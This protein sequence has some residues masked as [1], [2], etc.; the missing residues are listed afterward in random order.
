[1]SFECLL[2][3][4]EAPTLRVDGEDS[5]THRNCILEPSSS[6]PSD[7]NNI[8]LVKKEINTGPSIGVNHIVS[9][10]RVEGIRELQNLTLG[11]AQE[12]ANIL[13]VVRYLILRVTSLI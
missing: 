5:D 10:L 4:C 8:V 13:D 12:Y 6:C 11:E 3:A 2:H 7:Q 1:M 9:L